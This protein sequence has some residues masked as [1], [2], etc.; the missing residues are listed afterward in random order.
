MNKCTFPKKYFIITIAFILVVVL[1]VCINVFTVNLC[2][3]PASFAFSDFDNAFAEKI[4]VPDDFYAVKE[5]NYKYRNGAFSA[6]YYILIGMHPDADTSDYSKLSDGNY[7]YATQLYVTQVN[8][9]LF[10]KVPMYSYEIHYLQGEFEAHVYIS[11]SSN[12]NLNGHKRF[13]KDVA[14]NINALIQEN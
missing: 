12:P 7:C 6:D 4:T 14:K 13:L 8:K 2:S 11:S 9:I 1:L 10:L 5:K 3:Y